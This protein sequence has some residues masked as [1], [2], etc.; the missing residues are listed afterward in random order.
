MVYSKVFYFPICIICYCWL[1]YLAVVDGLTS[2]TLTCSKF[3]TATFNAVSC[4]LVL[5]IVNN[6]FWYK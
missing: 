4:M 6:T 3:C 1:Y 5:H 2:L